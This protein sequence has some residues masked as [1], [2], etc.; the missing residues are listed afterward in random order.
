MEEEETYFEDSMDTI[1]L[2][3]SIPEFENSEKQCVFWDRI[4]SVFV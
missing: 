4:R 3:L 2:I 1:L